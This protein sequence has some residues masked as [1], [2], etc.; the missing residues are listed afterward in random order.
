[1]ASGAGCRRPG[2]ASVHV[3]LR[4]GNAGVRAGE[5][6]GSLVVI[7][8]GALPRGRGM[9]GGAILREVLGYVIRARGLLKIGQVAAR[10]L[11]RGARE[12]SVRVALGA[13]KRDMRPGQCEFRRRV[14]IEFGPLPLGGR[15][16]KRAVLRKPRGHVVRAGGLLEIGQVAAG[17][18]ERRRG[19]V[20][21]HMTLCAVHG[22]VRAGEREPCRGVVEFSALPVGC[23][24]AGLARRGESALDVVRIRRL[25]EIRQVAAR[26][27][28][29]CAGEPAVHVALRALHAGVGAG[30]GKRREFVVIEGCVLPCGR[31]MTLR[32]IV[33]ESGRRVVGVLHARKIADVAA[34]AVAGSA[35]KPSAHVARGAFEL[36]VRAGKREW[37]EL[38]VVEPRALPPVHSVARVARDRQVGC[39]MIQRLGGL[40]ILEMARRALGAQSRENAA[41]RSLVAVFA[42][43]RSVS[44]EQRKTVAVL[45]D[46]R[47]RDLPALDGVAI[48]AVG[49]ELAAMQVGMA[50]RAARRGLRELQVDVAIA[51][52][53][54]LVHSAQ[55]ERGLGIVLELRPGPDRLPRRG[56]MAVLAGNLE[57]SVRIG[58]AAA[59]RVLCR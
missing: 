4:A 52:L 54:S 51:A 17:A 1:M 55:R 12:D 25:V 2:E 45:A 9:A 39:R 18:L 31:R 36:G 14:V 46:G 33:R 5:G 19:V 44:A 40:I 59:D 11:H 42:C 58:D 16:A 29:G 37:C 15:M 57:G 22:R 23:V 53:D 47:D 3:A 32:A 35:L 26:A 21:V 10:A 8:T 48:L 38:R 56:R 41:G 7:E 13:R 50:I 20:A 30:E 6:E 34:E 49:S 28:H 24:V 43:R 27:I